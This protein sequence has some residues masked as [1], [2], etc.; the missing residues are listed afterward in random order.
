MSTPPDTLPIHLPQEVLSE[1][2]SIG[3]GDAERGARIALAAANLV[4]ETPDGARID[5]NA[6]TLRILLA[7]TRLT[8]TAERLASHIERYE[9]E[10][11]A[12]LDD[13]ARLGRIEED[14]PE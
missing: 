12:F 9:L 3:D 1:F 8:E 5:P 6:S 10:R 13:V 11:H 2:N 7:A 14:T 4:A